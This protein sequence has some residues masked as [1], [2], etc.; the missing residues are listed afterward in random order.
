[1]S[2]LFPLGYEPASTNEDLSALRTKYPNLSNVYL[3]LH[4]RPDWSYAKCFFDGIWSS[5][6]QFADDNFLPELQANFFSNRSWELFLFHLLQENGLKMVDQKRNGPNPDF[7]IDLGNQNLFVEA[8]SA[9]QGTGHNRVETISD[10]LSGSTSGQVVSQTRSFDEANHPKVRR[11]MNAL[12]EKM[13]NYTE[14]HSTVVRNV[15]FYVIA[16]SAGDIEG[17]MASSP[18]ALILEAVKGINPAIHIPLKNDGSYGPEYHTSRF[19]IPNAKG[20]NTIDLDM[21]SQDEFKQ[22]SGVIY[23]GRDVIN[24]V[25]QDAKPSEAIFVHNPN[26]LPGKALPMNIFSR[27]T[28]I[29]IS[30]TEWIRH[31]PPPLK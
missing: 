11:I 24:A 2:E 1:M 22:I 26:V 4:M 15:D 18:E 20:T 21:F 13:R 9:G 27:F 25:L 5:F 12:D 17:S 7:K 19:S 30:P 8:V 23:F 29:T 6:R 31:A 28:Q 16:L 3:N 14:N 10:L